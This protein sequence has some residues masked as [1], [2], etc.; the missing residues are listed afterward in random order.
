MNYWS[1]YQTSKS[2][3]P[4]PIQM[5]TNTLENCIKVIRKQEVLGY[6]LKISTHVYHWFYKNPG[7]CI[8]YLSLIYLCADQVFKVHLSPNSKIKWTLTTTVVW[9]FLVYNFV[10]WATSEWPE[11]RRGKHLEA[12]S[13]CWFSHITYLFI[14]SDHPSLHPLCVCF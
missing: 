1:G 7:R 3:S 10:Q 6:V 12:F 5:E 11:L 2:P 9:Q 14:Y 8:P 4:F 13:L